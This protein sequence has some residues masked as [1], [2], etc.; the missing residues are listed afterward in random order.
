MVPLEPEAQRMRELFAR[1][2]DIPRRLESRPEWSVC[3]LQVGRLKARR[4]RRKRVRRAARIGG[5]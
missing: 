1:E 2:A 4:E 5:F 3:G